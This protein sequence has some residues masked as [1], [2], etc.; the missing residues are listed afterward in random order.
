MHIAWLTVGG[1]VGERCDMAMVYMVNQPII[2]VDNFEPWPHEGF[3]YILSRSKR[4]RF[5]QIIIGDL[6]ELFGCVTELQMDKDCK[7]K[8]L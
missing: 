1:D 4:G 6:A 3:D 7:D 2:T 5:W 8:T